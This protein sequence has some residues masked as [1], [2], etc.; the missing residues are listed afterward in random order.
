MSL[1]ELPQDSYIELWKAIYFGTPDW[2]EYQYATLQGRTKKKK[3][4]LFKGAKMVCAELCDLMYSEEPEIKASADMLAILERSGWNRNI[5]QFSEKVLALGGGAFKLYTKDNLIYIDYVPADRFIPVSW[6]SVRITEADFIDRRVVDKKEFIRIEKHRKT[7]TGYNISEEFYKKGEKNQ[8]AKA[9]AY[10]LGI[11]D[12]DPKGVDIET[13]MPL[14][15]YIRLPEAN[16][17]DTE[18]PNGIS[19]FHNSIDTLE[20]L[21]I[22]FDGLQAEIQLGKKRII[23]PA[24]AVRKVVDSEG[25]LVTYF[26]PSDEVYQAFESNDKED[27]KITDNSVELRVDEI[28]MAIQTYLD[29]LSSQIGFSNGYL[30]FDGQR[31]VKTATEIMSENSKT[32][33]TKINIENSFKIAIMDL[34]EGIRGIENLYGINVGE[35]DYIYQ[36]NI[37]QDKDS[38][39]TYWTDRL[40]NKTCTLEQFLMEVD[41]LTESE[42]KTKAKLIRSQTATVDIDNMFGNDNRFNNYT[43]EEVDE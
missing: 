26:D 14:F 3:R 16:N 33:K 18:K 27:L 30:T 34:V 12:F 41:N 6:D 21:D 40:N 8:L 25:N 24:S 9:S 35:F 4:K 1:L 17:T 10:E 28:R 36:D 39:T 7:A 38:I 32:L 29:I 20:G 42:A 23:V 43:V 15:S 13:N 2:L 37:H 19:I 5:K 11:V 22:A 31:G